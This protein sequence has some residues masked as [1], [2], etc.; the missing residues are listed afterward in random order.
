[1]NNS[2]RRGYT[3]DDGILSALILHAFLK[4]SPG[5]MKIEEFNLLDVFFLHNLPPVGIEEVRNVAVVVGFGEA[6]VTRLLPQ[7]PDNLRAV[8]VKDDDRDA[9]SEVFEVLA[10]P[11]GL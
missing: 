10:H 11:I 6:A 9:K 7:Q 4:V 3:A 2:V 5:R 1:M 8:R